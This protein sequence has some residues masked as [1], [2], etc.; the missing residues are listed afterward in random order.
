[1]TSK[2]RNIP[3]VKNTTSTSLIQPLKV[4]CDALIKSNNISTSQLLKAYRQLSRSLASDH[5]DFQDKVKHIE[6]ATELCKG[7]IAQALIDG[8]KRL[9]HPVDV[10]SAGL[11]LEDAAKVMKDHFEISLLA[12]H[13]VTCISR[14]PALAGFITHTDHLLAKAVAAVLVTTA[15]PPDLKSKGQIAL[16]F[17]LRQNGFKEEAFLAAAEK[18]SSNMSSILKSS[19]DDKVRSECLRT[20]HIICA[21]HLKLL[22][23]FGKNTYPRILEMALD[24]DS[25]VHPVALQA[26]L[27][28]AQIKLRTPRTERQGSFTLA[29]A[30]ATF[31]N[32]T[33]STSTSQDRNARLKMALRPENFRK[34]ARPYWTIPFISALIVI[35]GW[36]AIAHDISATVFFQLTQAVADTKRASLLH[37][38]L[39]RCIVF[40]YDDTFDHRREAGLADKAKSAASILLDHPSGGVGEA[41]LSVILRRVKEETQMEEMLCALCKMAENGDK[42]TRK[43][44]VDIFCSALSGRTE[45]LSE[46]PTPESFISPLILSD[47]LANASKTTIENIVERACSLPIKI[48]WQVPSDKIV[49]HWL[50][51][52]KTWAVCV[53]SCL[54]CGEQVP[55][56]LLSTWEIIARVRFNPLRPYQAEEIVQDYSEAVTSLFHMPAE[57]QCTTLSFL[58]RWMKANAVLPSSTTRRLAAKLLKVVVAAEWAYCEEAVQAQWAI[59]ANDLLAPAASTGTIQLTRLFER[60]FNKHV[61]LARAMWA[62]LAEIYKAN[63]DPDEKDR[64]PA[65]FIQLAYGRWP[66][67]DYELGLWRHCAEDV[68]G[69]AGEAWALEILVTEPTEKV[70]TAHVQRVLLVAMV[71]GLSFRKLKN[72]ALDAVDDALCQCYPPEKVKPSESHVRAALRLLHILGKQLG[73]LPLDEMLRVLHRMRDG[74]SAWLMDDSGIIEIGEHAELVEQLYCVPLDAIRPKHEPSM[75]FLNTMGEWC[76]SG[77]SKRGDEKTRASDV[78]EAFWK[79]TYHHRQEFRQYPDSIVICLRI[80]HDMGRHFVEDDVPES[81]FTPLTIVPDSCAEPSTPH[82]RVRQRVNVSGRGTPSASATPKQTSQKRQREATPT[83]GPKSKKRTLELDAEEE[84]EHAVVKKLEFAA[85]PQKRRKLISKGVVIPAFDSGASGKPSQLLTPCPSDG[86]L[87]QGVDEFDESGSGVKMPLRKSRV[88]FPSPP[89]VEE[90]Q[91][92]EEEVVEEMEMSQSRDCFYPPPEDEEDDDVLQGMEMSQ[93]RDCL[94]PSSEGNDEEEVAQMAMSQSRD[95]PPSEEED[96]QPEVDMMEMQSQARDDFEKEE[97]DDEAKSAQLSFVIPD[98]MPERQES[99]QQPS[100]PARANS[101]PVIASERAPDLRRT[102]TAPATIDEAWEAVQRAI[103]HF[104]AFQLDDAHREKGRG[105]AWDFMNHFMDRRPPTA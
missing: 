36:T 18:L 84:K 5:P 81:Q 69:R 17:F 65:E 102:Q 90:E 73:D 48:S 3:T 99:P 53:K 77:L 40:A 96:E 80:L 63:R 79:E 95:Y 70:S 22:R 44:A 101:L 33:S 76:V 75:E 91:D 4:I 16:L 74:L 9:G 88:R 12:I 82:Q 56:C 15:P 87:S 98:A 100:S 89:P 72:P 78:F 19:K 103:G 104:T 51:L 43:S 7:S 60:V 105:V 26:I 50:E 68:L 52:V 54:M 46:L 85:S 1:M 64:V 39:L 66:M 20:V 71:K 45:N 6:A 23:S 11:S 37:T 25:T 67:E 13:V 14:I 31:V 32:T 41:V 10:D 47:E 59:L 97:E 61:A 27:S 34:T 83:P 49:M 93:S 57:H 2:P 24:A 42:D 21:K 38:Q 62:T 28:T 29:R 86:D 8:V 58:S 30:I 35:S 55:E 92:E 94:Y